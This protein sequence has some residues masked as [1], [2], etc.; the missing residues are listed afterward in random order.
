MGRY[1]RN[2]REVWWTLAAIFFASLLFNI[3]WLRVQR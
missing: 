1:N 2:P 3:L